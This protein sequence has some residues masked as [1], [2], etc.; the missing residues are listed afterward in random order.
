MI[1]AEQSANREKDQTIPSTF[2][3]AARKVRGIACKGNDDNGHLPTKIKK[4]DKKKKKDFKREDVLEAEEEGEPIGDLFPR[5]SWEGI[6][7]S[8]RLFPVNTT[9]RLYASAA[10]SN[11]Q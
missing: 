2:Y 10:Y 3:F 11:S 6:K 1:I 5:P 7:R 4:K 9:V 8:V